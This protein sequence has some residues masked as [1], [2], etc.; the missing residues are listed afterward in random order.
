MILT[1]LHRALQA[2]INPN[3][4]YAFSP[5]RAV[6]TFH[7][8]YKKWSVNAVYRDEIAL[9]YEIRKQLTN[10]LSG[11]NVELFNVKRGCIYRKPM[12]SRGLRHLQ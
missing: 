11:Q 10:K 4:I 6:N 9:F 3:Y 1:G 7:L 2:H 8:G 12:G 5:Y